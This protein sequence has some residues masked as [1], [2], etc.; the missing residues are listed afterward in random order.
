MDAFFYCY[1][2]SQ[3]PVLAE[4]FERAKAGKPMRQL[5]TDR[6]SI[7]DPPASQQGDIASW[8]K[9]VNNSTTQLEHQSNRWV[10]FE[11]FWLGRW[12]NLFFFF[13]RILNLE[14]L[15]KF[16]GNA[17]RYHNFEVEGYVKMLE[18]EL[19]AE[20]QEVTNINKKRKAAQVKVLLIISHPRTSSDRFK[21]EQFEAHATISSLQARLAD[22]RGASH[23]VEAA[24]HFLEA[25]V[26]QLRKKS[27]PDAEAD[28]STD[29]Q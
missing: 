8:Q 25:D 5:D 6:Y 12:K 1:L 7:Q 11:I 29:N 16:G 4:E 17:W 3:S 26:E 28:P 18:A 24:S 23:R 13:V 9:A 15:Q 22:L 2:L 20:Q 19:Q 21:F 10:S 14:L 27:K